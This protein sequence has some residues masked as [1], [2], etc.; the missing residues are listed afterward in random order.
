MNVKT[1]AISNKTYHRRRTYIT[2]SEAIVKG[3][4]IK[5]VL[6]DIIIKK[7]VINLNGY[8]RC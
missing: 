1:T 2:F 4:L 5:N 3:L 7:F 6:N 8:N